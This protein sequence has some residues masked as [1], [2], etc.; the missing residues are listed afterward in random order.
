MLII[1]FDSMSAW[2]TDGRTDGR[3]ITA[4]AAVADMHGRCAMNTKQ[5]K[6]VLRVQNDFSLNTLCNIKNIPIVSWSSRGHSV[7]S[8]RSA[9]VL[10]STAFPPADTWY[11]TYDTITAVWWP[12]I[13]DNPDETVSQLSETLTHYTT[14]TVHKFLISTPKFP[15]Q[16]SYY[17]SRV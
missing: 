8:L 5:V 15:S 17:I 4:L 3:T 14:F 12:F 1:R 7:I 11:V 16:A 10:I 13:P 2:Q 6:R 9:S